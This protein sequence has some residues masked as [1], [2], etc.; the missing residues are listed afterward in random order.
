M[1]SNLSAIIV[2]GFHCR[3]GCMYWYWSFIPFCFSR[4]LF[5][6]KK[7]L[8]IQRIRRSGISK[9]LA[10]KCPTKRYSLPDVLIDIGSEPYALYRFYLIVAASVVSERC[11]FPRVFIASAFFFAAHGRRKSRSTSSRQPVMAIWRRY[12]NSSYYSSLFYSNPISKSQFFR[13]VDAWVG[14]ITFLLYIISIVLI[15]NW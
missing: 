2:F 14:R 6:K 5:Y 1:Q 11:T 12:R 8:A 10:K 13:I 15:L 7:K 4:H 3:I 9:T